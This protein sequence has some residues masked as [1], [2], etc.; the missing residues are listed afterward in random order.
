M[1]HE[2]EATL[3]EKFEIQVQ[4]AVR[5]TTGDIEVKLTKIRGDLQGLTKEN[6]NLK[7]T[8]HEMTME[9]QIEQLTNAFV[10]TKKM[11]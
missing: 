9:K 5:D 11:G 6:E 7:E 8:Q 4:K 3:S 10:K 1:S 2:I